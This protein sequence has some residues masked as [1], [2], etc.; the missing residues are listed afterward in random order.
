ML[1]ELREYINYFRQSGK[2]AVSY[3][4]TGGEAIPFRTYP[5]TWVCLLFLVDCSSHIHIQPLH[6]SQLTY[7]FCSGEK[8]YYL[9]TSFSEYYAAPSASFALRGL[10]VSGTI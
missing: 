9:A 2:F 6:G 8:E 10:A 5:Y 4:Y 1:Q 7:G 3:M